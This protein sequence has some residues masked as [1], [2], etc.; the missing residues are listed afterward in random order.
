MRHHC[1]ALV[2]GE[3]VC[4]SQ[5]EVT[6]TAS[7]QA[8]RQMFIYGNSL[9]DYLLAVVVPTQGALTHTPRKAR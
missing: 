4:V 7:S 5:L 2:Q 1:F 9:R 3:Y 6:Y 8:V